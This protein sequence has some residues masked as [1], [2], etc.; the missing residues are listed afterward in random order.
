M[1][2]N[3]TQVV[4]GLF[5]VVFL[6]SLPPLGTVISWSLVELIKP[7]NIAVRGVELRFLCESEIPY[8][9]E[10]SDYGVR[11][12]HLGKFNY[13]YAMK[14]LLIVCVLFVGCTKPKT[15]TC[16]TNKGQYKVHDA[17]AAEIRK[18][19]RVNAEVEMK[20]H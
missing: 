16:D 6:V 14:K 8:F 12:W 7:A 3:A 1:H 9:R 5:S 17:T 2:H 15:W 18:M 19:E 4:Q 11:S 10:I 20:C 13:F